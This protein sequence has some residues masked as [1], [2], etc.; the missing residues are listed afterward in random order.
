MD[1]NYEWNQLKNISHLCVSVS[2]ARAVELNH[3]PSLISALANETAKLFHE[4]E[5][6]LSSLDV[7]VAGQWRKYL[8]L[9]YNFYMA[10]VRSL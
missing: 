8:Q 3:S 6:A 10:Y 5:V 9:K 7:K 4:A 1:I 2:V